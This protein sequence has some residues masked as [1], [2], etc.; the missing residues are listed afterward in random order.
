MAVY[1]LTFSVPSATPPEAP[2][3]YEMDILEPWII[4]VEIDFPSASA[5][6][7]TNLVGA[8]VKL[9]NTP[10][11][12]SSTMVTNLAAGSGAVTASDWITSMGD[13][14]APYWGLD[15]G[16]LHSP[17]KLR[18]EAYNKLAAAVQIDVRIQTAMASGTDLAYS[19]VRALK[20][21]FEQ[22][23]T[24]LDRALEAVQKGGK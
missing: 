9:R 24:L 12:P 21:I 7:G 3:A 15:F 14:A 2:V 20:E 6:S 8:R 23:K 4:Q 5:P 13:G 17:E 11:V 1:A 18:V 19:T 16:P 10:F 22:H